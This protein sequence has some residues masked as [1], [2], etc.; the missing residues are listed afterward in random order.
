[1]GQIVENYVDPEQHPK[2][3]LLIKIDF[4]NILIYH[5]LSTIIE[6]VKNIW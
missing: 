3:I 2:K 4:Y 5:T 1:M 6:N